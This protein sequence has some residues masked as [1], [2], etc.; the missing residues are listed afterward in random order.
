M[1]VTPSLSFAPLQLTTAED[2]RRFKRTMNS[3]RHGIEVI[4]ERAQLYRDRCRRGGQFEPCEIAIST[5][6][7]ETPDGLVTELLIDGRSVADWLDIS[8]AS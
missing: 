4:V 2:L 6:E 3:V 8:G 5:R 7:R 1:K